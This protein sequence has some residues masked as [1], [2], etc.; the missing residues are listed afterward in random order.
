MGLERCCGVE[1]LCIT[2]GF[3]VSLAATVASL[4]PW[5]VP[6]GQGCTDK[7]L[8]PQDRPNLK[9]GQGEAV[10]RGSGDSSGP[11]RISLVPVT[12]SLFAAQSWVI[13]TLLYSLRR[14]GT[15][16]WLQDRVTCA[17]VPD[18]NGCPL[19]PLSVAWEPPEAI[20]QASPGPER[21]VHFPEITWTLGPSPHP[22]GGLG[23]VPAHLWVSV[24]PSVQGR[25]PPLLGC[26]EA[27]GGWLSA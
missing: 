26:W 13:I 10:G 25:H 22:A 12:Q 19:T 3:S 14:V 7:H 2:R 27:G 15:Q 6:E 17:L 16:G 4:Q 18:W 8:A 24:S 1:R 5:E 20:Q 11:R 23:R 21:A 9:V